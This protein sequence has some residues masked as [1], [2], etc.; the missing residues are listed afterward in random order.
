MKEKRTKDLKIGFKESLLLPG[1]GV[2]G[3]VGQGD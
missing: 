3:N 2:K 1:Y